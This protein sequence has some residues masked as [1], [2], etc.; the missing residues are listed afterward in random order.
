MNIPNKGE[1]FLLISSFIYLI[2]NNIFF[3]VVRIVHGSF[4][5]DNISFRLIGNICVSRG[6]D[7]KS[8]PYFLVFF[9]L[10]LALLLVFFI[11]KKQTNYLIEVAKVVI[12]SIFILDIVV[13]LLNLID[14]ILGSEYSRFY[15]SSAPLF[16]LSKIYLSSYNILPLLSGFFGI[17]V[18]F[19]KFREKFLISITLILLGTLLYI[20]CGKIGE[21][22]VVG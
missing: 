4:S 3:N 8:G 21:A 13:V 7:E 19:K 17:T 14:Q 5:I 6:P 20:L 11:P 12:L 9:F 18:F 1:L 10:K 16:L 2:V 15:F 22:V